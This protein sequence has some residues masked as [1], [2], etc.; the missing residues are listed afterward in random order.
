MKLLEVRFEHIRCCI[1][2]RML[3]VVCLFMCGRI[4]VVVDFRIVSADERVQRYER[5]LCMS[6]SSLKITLHHLSP[7]HILKNKK[8]LEDFLSEK[9][10]WA[11]SRNKNIAV[12]VSNN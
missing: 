6:V 1:W 7:D 12:S 9:K 4:F 3:L 2:A 8:Y 11:L 5:A 10:L